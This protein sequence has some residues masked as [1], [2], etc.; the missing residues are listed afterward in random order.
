[1]TRFLV[2]LALTGSL[3]G[4]VDDVLTFIASL[5]DPGPALASALRIVLSLTEPAP[6]PCVD[7]SER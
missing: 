3:L 7:V 4:A 1:M 5:R 6:T 2:A